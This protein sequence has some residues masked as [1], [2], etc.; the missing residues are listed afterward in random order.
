MKFSKNTLGNKS[1]LHSQFVSEYFGS[2][3]ELEDAATNY[4]D[5]RQEVEKYISN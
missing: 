3:E 1:W 4:D 2:P 5:L